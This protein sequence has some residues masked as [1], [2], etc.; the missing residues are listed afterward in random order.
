MDD[1]DQ[2][3]LAAIVD[4]SDDAILSKDLKGT[5]RT[6]NPAAERLF[7]YR[8]GEIIGK[9]IMLLI[10]RERIAE[11][12]LILSKM[13]RGER[14]EHYE[15][16]RVRKDGR[17]INVSISVAPLAD[18][19]GRIIGASKIVRDISDRNRV[20]SAL[21]ESEKRLSAIVETAVDAIIT[22][23]ERGLIESANAATQRMFGYRT[24]ELIGQNVKMLMPAP[25]QAEHDQ[26]LQTYLRTGR[27]RIIGIGRE[28]T[29]L[30]KDGT[31]F[32]MNLSVSEV[33]LE[34]KRLFTGI[35]HDLTN[36]RQLERQ[37]IE[38]SAAEQRRIGQDLHDGLCQDLVGIAFQI[39]NIARQPGAS[40]AIA[41][42]AGRISAAVR[43]A[44][45]Q[46]RQLSHGLNPVDL[47]AGG[48][49]VALLGLA[50][51]I[52]DSFGVVCEFH[53]DEIA[54]ADDDATATHLF[55]IAQEAISNAIKHGT[56]RRIDIHLEMSNGGMML[57]VKDDGIGLQASNG[58]ASRAHA[59]DIPH[60]QSPREGIGLQGMHY[61]AHLIGGVFDIRARD[62]R[63]TIVSC[64]I[65]KQQIV[66][67]KGTSSPEP[68]RGTNAGASDKFRSRR[69]GKSR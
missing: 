34:G 19:R 7:G 51:K 1:Q 65:A 8:A 41:R 13:R 66:S 20:E 18:A 11:E 57:T 45:L 59:R 12:K 62:R 32:P 54:Q 42:E 50:R 14:V 22:I 21:R 47:D 49:P 60:S 25:Y 40:P 46:A 3:R 5:V 36:R 27:A 44:A 16:V 33:A 43:Q 24:S 15:T 6:W 9:S 2:A 69:H 56:A 37:I 35:I 29:A 55:R 31:T 58:R 23:D 38:A 68:R 48:L 52:S 63:G 61:R 28:V 30:R 64:H 10:P 17:A 39:D 53:W 67:A 26:Y 4:C